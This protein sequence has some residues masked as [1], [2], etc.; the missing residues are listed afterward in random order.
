MMEVLKGVKKVVVLNTKVPR[1][2]EDQ[3]NQ[4]LA[5]GVKKY[6]NQAVLVDW[7]TIAGEHPEFFWD[8][9]FHLRPEGAQYYAQLIAGYL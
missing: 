9:G 8:D 7:H 6:K 1:P 4:V 3:V 2:W 5:D